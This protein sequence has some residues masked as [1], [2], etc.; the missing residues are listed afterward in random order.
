VQSKSIFGSCMRPNRG[1]PGAW[2]RCGDKIQG[3]RCQRRH[4]QRLAN[5]ARRLRPALMVVEECAASRE[6]EQYSAA[7]QRQHAVRARPPRYGSLRSHN[8]RV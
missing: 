4:V 3:S 7:Q 8:F 2:P 6:K 5:M 1:I